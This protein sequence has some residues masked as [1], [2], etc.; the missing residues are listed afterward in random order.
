[1]QYHG[2]TTQPCSGHAF[3][4]QAFYSG[5]MSRHIT[6]LVYQ[7]LRIFATSSWRRTGQSLSMRGI[8][9]ILHDC[10]P[11]LLGGAALSLAARGEGV[12]GSKCWC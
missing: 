8:M 9:A 12:E 2:A 4:S 1:M 10:P 11:S 5:R 6:S 3:I 7:P